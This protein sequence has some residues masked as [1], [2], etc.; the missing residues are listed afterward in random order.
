MVTVI[1]TCVCH[2]S[3]VFSR[4][5]SVYRSYVRAAG[6]FWFASVFVLYPLANAMTYVQTLSLTLWIERMDGGGPVAGPAFDKYIASAGG[7]ALLL[8][9]A[10]AARQIMSLRASLKL[11]E[12]MTTRVLRA[13]TSW[14]DATPVG[15]RD[16]HT[17][18]GA[19]FDRYS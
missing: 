7:Y 4:Q 8:L 5:A 14:F 16:R 3:H 6:V 1:L 2:T 15:R 13:R 19:F 18:L 17:T 10:I 12:W 11:H 9:V